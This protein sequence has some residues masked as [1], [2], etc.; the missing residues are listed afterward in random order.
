VA[1]AGNG[2]EAAMRV[3]FVTA[4]EYAVEAYEQAADTGCVTGGRR[5]LALGPRQQG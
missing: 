2:I 4:Y 3:V 5:T 1:S